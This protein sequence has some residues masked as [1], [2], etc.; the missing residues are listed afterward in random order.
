MPRYR[1]EAPDGRTLTVEGDSPPTDQEAEALFASQEPAPAAAPQAPVD[2]PS[3]A[4]RAKANFTAGFTQSSPGYAFRKAGQMAANLVVPGI[5]TVA[6]ALGAPS[7]DEEYKQFM[8]QY[9]AM[10]D[11]QGALEH[12]VAIGSNIAGGFVAPENFIPVGKAGTVGARFAKGALATGA[13]N[14]AV[15]TA[16]Q[17]GDVATGVQKNFDYYRSALA[18]LGGAALGGAINAIPDLK[19]ASRLR[20]F[21]KVGEADVPKMDIKADAPDA[22]DGEMLT[23]YVSRKS[24]EIA[25][26]K[27]A[28]GQPLDINTDSVRGFINKTL[29]QIENV[30]T[31]GTVQPK[32]IRPEFTMA[33]SLPEEAV[34]SPGIVQETNRN[35]VE[36]GKLVK[37]LRREADF[38]A[39]GPTSDA[40]RTAE[41]M[42]GESVKKW[43]TAR[44]T[45]GLS[46]R[47]YQNGLDGIRRIANL[48]P[49]MQ[50]VS[51]KLPILNSL[52]KNVREMRGT[53]ALK[54]LV[55]F[56]RQNMFGLL[57]VNLDLFGNLAATAVKAPGWIAADAY[58]LATGGPANRLAGIV[59]SIANPRKAFNIPDVIKREMGT[60]FSGEQSRVM[61]DKPGLDWILALPVKLK[62]AADSYFGHTFAAADLYSSALTEAR[63]RNLRGFDKER[64]IEAFIK[65]PSDEA[66]TSA[67]E[68]GS[69]LKFNRKLSKLEEGIATNL[70]TKLFFDAYPRWS[71]QFTRWAAETLGADTHFFN[72]VKAGKA[73]GRDVAEYLTNMATGWGGV[74]LANQFYDNID[75]K[76]MEYVREDGNRVRLSNLAPIPDALALAALAH[77]DYAKAKSAFQYSS[78]FGSQA[79][80]LRGILSDLLRTTEQ[81]FK[82]D[83]TA[84][85]LGDELINTANQMIPGQAVL[86]AIESFVNPSMQTGFGS[87]VPGVSEFKPTRPSVTTGEP[88][89]TRQKLPIVGIEVPA[90]R[91]VAFPGA[92]K[93]VN[94]VERAL[95]EHGLATYRPRRSPL[96]SLAAPDVPESLRLEYEKYLGQ[97]TKKFIEPIVTKKTFYNAPFEVRR[98][99][100]ENMRGVANRM[101]KLELQRKHRD[102]KPAEKVPSNNVRLLPESILEEAKVNQ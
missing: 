20:K 70:G 8:A 74:A 39:D 101:A 86:S 51:K 11:S 6:K 36:L 88:M 15:D 77:G 29:D 3:L 27:P 66:T 79:V 84:V 97:Y 7:S 69:K 89:Q 35:L 81:S 82:G 23:D 22:K 95:L 91:G 60:T 26:A 63:K 73:G 93:I 47:E 46:L 14:L 30:A 58:D 61:I 43:Q 48:I 62:G 1:I 56:S 67:I 52:V 90:I 25:A 53:A 32:D 9:N 12:T 4:E 57:S 96:L 99:I 50:D 75:F 21:F 13:T 18:G 76:T 94:P 17:A 37:N 31:T 45:A 102:F 2:R 64:F 38:K 33:G 85:Q 78:L 98:T 55:D 87:N 100:L 16:M 59:R 71:F 10:P 44:K 42:F 28:P 24:K 72:R 34:V 92:T 54:D 49:E 41:Q 68:L 83:Y 5:G 65:N 19:L 40:L 80:S